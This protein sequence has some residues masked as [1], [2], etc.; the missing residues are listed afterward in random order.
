MQKT[1]AMKT[2]KVSE[3][4]DDALNWLVAKCEG[5]LLND[6]DNLLPKYS[7]DWAQGGPIIERVCVTIY[8]SGA[9]SIEPKNPDYWVAEILEADEMLTQYGPTPLVA[10]MRCYVASKLGEYVEVPE[11]LMH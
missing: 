6:A 2:V 5:Q 10:A 8:A 1:I 7:T 3:V 9:C 4:T 11:D